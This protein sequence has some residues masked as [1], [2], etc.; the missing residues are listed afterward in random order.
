V[1]YVDEGAVLTSAGVRRAW[2]CACTSCV[3]TTARPRPPG[4]IRQGGNAARGRLGPRGPADV[5]GHRL[6]TD[7]LAAVAASTGIGSAAHLRNLSARETA[8]APSAYRAAHR[9]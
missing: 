1:L 2:T 8:T 4:W 3:S 6:G 5:S 7:L 9:G